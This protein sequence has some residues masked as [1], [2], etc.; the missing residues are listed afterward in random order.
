MLRQR[1]WTIMIRPYTTESGT[2]MHYT[3][4]PKASRSDFG[5]T[6]TSEVSL[7]GNKGGQPNNSTMELTSGG[8]TEWYRTSSYPKLRVKYREALYE[9]PATHIMVVEIIP[10]DLEATPNS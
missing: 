9:F 3:G 2:K 7:S 10:M 5:Q 6:G 1:M 4:T 8:W